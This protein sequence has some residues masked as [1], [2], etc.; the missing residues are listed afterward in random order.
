[1][2]IYLKKIIFVVISM[3]FCINQSSASDVSF[4]LYQIADNISDNEPDIK[5]P[6]MQLYKQANDLYL[7]QQLEEKRQAYEKAKANEQSLANR[8]LTAL[9]IA[10]MGIGGMELARG[11]AEQKADKEADQ[12]MTA[13]IETMY[14]RYGDG[15]QV[16]TGTEEIELP[17]GN[18]SEI[19]KLRN[20]Y[21]ALAA[22]LKKRKN[23]LGI[24]PG[25]ESEEI[26]DKSQT[27]L[28]DDKNIG[29]EKGVYES[30]YRAKMSD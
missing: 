23:A 1:M 9:S 14:C 16:K 13:Y 26:L 2:L 28:Y 15:K 11:L 12:N 10:T 25:I 24:K 6:Y 4:Y 5:S 29:I 3:L 17:G 21:F 20:E 22:D 27:G 7:Q 19:M 18:N 30:L 8:T